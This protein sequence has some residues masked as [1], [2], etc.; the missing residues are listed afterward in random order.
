MAPETLLFRHVR[1]VKRHQR[2][3]KSQEETC[4]LFIILTLSKD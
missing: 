1:I 3:E 2:L 4:F